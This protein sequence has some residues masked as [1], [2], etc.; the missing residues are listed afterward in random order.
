MKLH[1]NPFLEIQLFR[2]VLF[3]FFIHRH[4]PSKI[5]QISLHSNH[6]F[7]KDIF[8]LLRKHLESFPI[9][10]TILCLDIIQR[11]LFDIRVSYIFRD[12]R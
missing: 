2:S 4:N 8:S 5:C 6:A 3:P 11:L 1:I 10:L 9:S 12:A 7:L